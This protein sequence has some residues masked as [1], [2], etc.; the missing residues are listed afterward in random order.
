MTDTTLTE[1]GKSSTF[2]RRRLNI[3]RRLRECV[4]HIDRRTELHITKALARC[5]NV[6]DREIVSVARLINKGLR[7]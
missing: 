7:L 4:S 2:E 1:I 5:T 3:R 6:E